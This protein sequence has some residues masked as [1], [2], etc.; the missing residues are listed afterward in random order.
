[1][2]LTTI[3][4]FLD[5]QENGTCGTCKSLKQNFDHLK[6][7]DKTLIKA[8]YFIWTLNYVLP[9]AYPPLYSESTYLFSHS[10]V[11][12]VLLHAIMWVSSTPLLREKQSYAGRR[13]HLKTMHPYSSRILNEGPLFPFDAWC[14]LTTREIQVEAIY[15]PTFTAQSSIRLT[16][17]DRD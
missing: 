2:S 1:M 16:T 3:G 6:Q 8:Y 17:A 15:S 9:L 13:K 4:C 7:I 10:A 14:L 12:L 11:H 5:I